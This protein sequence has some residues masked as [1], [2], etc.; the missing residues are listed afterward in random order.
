[1]FYITDS[2]NRVLSD[3]SNHEAYWSDRFDSRLTFPHKVAVQVAQELAA[4]EPTLS[5]GVYQEE[6]QVVAGKMVA[7]I[8]A[9]YRRYFPSFRGADSSY[10]A[11]QHQFTFLFKHSTNRIDTILIT[12][13]RRVGFSPQSGGACF[14]MGCLKGWT[15]THSDPIPFSDRPSIERCSEKIF[16]YLSVHR[17]QFEWLRTRSVEAGK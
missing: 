10:S 7:E 4:R 11:K 9:I 6:P 17:E 8:T 2:Y 13:D 3:F 14:M 1:M 15:G 5:M 16:D 12:Q